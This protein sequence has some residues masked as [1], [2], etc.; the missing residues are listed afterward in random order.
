MQKNH[1]CFPQSLRVY[2]QGSRPD[3]RV[4]MREV[5]LS[6]TK[7]ADGLCQPNPGVRVYDASGP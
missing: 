1:T 3:I 2:A 4:P 7:G 5:M 6:P